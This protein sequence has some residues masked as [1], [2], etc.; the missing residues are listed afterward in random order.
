LVS[1]PTNT[2]SE[3]PGKI[4]AETNADANSP[5]NPTA[6]ENSNTDIEEQKWQPE[7]RR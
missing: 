5:H 2:T 3:L 7:S 6:A 1:K 4:V